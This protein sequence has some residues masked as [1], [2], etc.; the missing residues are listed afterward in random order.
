MG[1]AEALEKLWK[2]QAPAMRE[3]EHYRAYASLTPDMPEKEQEKIAKKANKCDEI[4]YKIEQGKPPSK[5]SNL[6][7]PVEA[8]GSKVGSGFKKLVQ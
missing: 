3:A 1:L 7:A 5:L 2:N 8:F 6:F 4:A